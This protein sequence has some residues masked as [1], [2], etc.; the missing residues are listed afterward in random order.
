MT[1]RQMDPK[2][3]KNEGYVRKKKLLLLLLL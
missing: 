2:S 1:K 3:P